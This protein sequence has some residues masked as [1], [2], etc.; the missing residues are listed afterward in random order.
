MKYEQLFLDDGTALSI[1][2]PYRQAV[3]EQLFQMF[4]QKE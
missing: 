2:Q 3:R 4:L 1:S